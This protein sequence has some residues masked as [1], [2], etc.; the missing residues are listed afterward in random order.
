MERRLGLVL[1]MFNLE[2]RPA[3]Y[4]SLDMTRGY[5]ALAAFGKEGW[6]PSVGVVLVLLWG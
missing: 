3:T 6:G 4:G 1:E 2:Q 5:G